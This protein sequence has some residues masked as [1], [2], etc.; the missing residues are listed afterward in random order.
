MATGTAGDSGQRY[1]TNQVH[2]LVKRIS[3]A[4]IGA[5]NAAVTV[6]ILP[7]RAFVT[8]G[9]THVITGFNDTT[10]DDLDIGVAGSDDDLFAS[11]VDVNSNALTTFDDLALA[12]QWSTTARRVTAN[13]I[14]AATADGSAG[15]A[16]VYM[17]YYIAPSIS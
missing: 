5:D 12:N 14:T 1:H 3:Y 17:E 8:Y 11:G 15:E 2:Y 13:F 6:G 4:D 16:I 9:H 10:G 7:P